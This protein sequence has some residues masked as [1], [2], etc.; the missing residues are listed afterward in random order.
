MVV[1]SIEFCEF[2]HAHHTKKV[3][4]I[5][6]R[7]RSELHPSGHNFEALAHL[8]ARMDQEDPLYIYKMNDRR[9]NNKPSFVFK[10]SKIQ[11]QL[12]LAMDRDSNEIL[13]KEYCFVDIEHNRCASFK[14]LAAH[15]Y[16]PLL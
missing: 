4:N 12:A 16:H 1:Q 7:V 11:A 15:V 2:W 5:K 8:K 10:T 3:R 13:N 6:Q 14:T 9:H